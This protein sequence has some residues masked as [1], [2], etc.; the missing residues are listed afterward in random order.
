MDKIFNVGGG[1]ERSTG[2]ERGSWTNP[3]LSS[4]VEEVEG[5]KKNDLIFVVVKKKKFEAHIY[6]LGFPPPPS[7]PPSQNFQPLPPSVQVRVHC[8]GGG[9]E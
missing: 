5:G 4:K 2:G 3:P 7:L 1:G 6:P 9:V 8:R